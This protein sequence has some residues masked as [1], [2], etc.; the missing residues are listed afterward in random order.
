MPRN[1][2]EA[3]LDAYAGDDPLRRAVARA[4][5]GVASAGRVLSAIVSEGPHGTDHAS[6]VGANLGG[7]SQKALDLKAHEILRDAMNWA[8]VAVF[9]SEEADLPDY[10]DAAGLVAVATDPLDGSSNIDTNVSIGTIFSVLPAGEN[11]FLQPGNRQL[12][13]GYVIYGPHT[14][15]VLTLGQGTLIF[16]LDRATGIYSGTG[17]ALTIAPE[18]DEFA[19]NA[20]NYRHWAEGIRAYVDDCVAG[21]AGPREKEFNMRWIASLVAE[22][23]RILTRGGVF[24]YPG[25]GRR[26]Y[27]EGRLR[28]VYE[29]NPIAMVVEQAGGRASAG[30]VRILD[31]VPTELHQRTPL[32][33]GSANEVTRVEF[34]ETNPVSAERSP[35]FGYRGLFRA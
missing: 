3:V 5:L 12:A 13:A 4:V 8:G 11:P 29:A 14:D 26:G 7:D 23:S 6:I 35:L 9:G 25:D 19:I 15:L 21:D 24:L 27:A 2:L 10:L 16:T 18:T 17:R 31:L 30:G 34:Y 20:S 32:V 22:T 28:L 33:F 1:S